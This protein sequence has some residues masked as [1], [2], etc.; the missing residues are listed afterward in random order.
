[1]IKALIDALRGREGYAGMAIYLGD[2]LLFCDGF[3]HALAD[4]AKSLFSEAES[5]FSSH[6]ITAVIRGFT[7]SAFRQDSLLVITRSEGRFTSLPLPGPEEPEYVVTG[8]VTRL[9]TRE[10]ARREAEHM[11]GQLMKAD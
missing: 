6:R 1:M 11:L 7:V 3:E 9:I 2:G 5:S 8:P 10:E 4:R